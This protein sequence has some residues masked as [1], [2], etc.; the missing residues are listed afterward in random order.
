M[1]NS[2]S[3]Q[4]TPGDRDRPSAGYFLFC[5][6]PIE[7]PCDNHRIHSGFS[8]IQISHSV[9]I[10]HSHLIYMQIPGSDRWHFLVSPAPRLPLQIS[11]PMMAFPAAFP[12][13]FSA[14]FV[15]AFPPAF[16]PVFPAAFPAAFPPA[17][18]SGTGFGHASYADDFPTPVFF[19]V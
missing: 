16:P 19:F 15:A 2:S 14:A 5:S 3:G 18:S 4:S 10:S 11:S 17:F 13:A 8:P 9:Q 1:G 6:G 12:V 7:E